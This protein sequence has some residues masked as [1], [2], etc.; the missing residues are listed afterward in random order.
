[1]TLPDSALVGDDVEIKVVGGAPNGC[2]SDLELTMQKENDSLY[3]IAGIGVYESW[4]GLCT[5][6]YPLIDSTF[7][8]EPS[9]AGT[10]RFIA[11]SLNNVRFVDTLHVVAR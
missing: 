1:M 5:D 9:R 7:T 6:I 3:N 8:F 2:W 4:D 11:Y 10:Y